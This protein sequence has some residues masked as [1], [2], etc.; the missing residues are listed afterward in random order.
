MPYL[1]DK[2]PLFNFGGGGPVGL[3]ETG[4]HFGGGGAFMSRD[5]FDRVGACMGL[6][7]PGA[8]FVGNAARSMCSPYVGAASSCT[9][10]GPQFGNA[11]T[12][13]PPFSSSTMPP[14]HVQAAWH[15]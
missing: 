15:G 13:G 5:Q 14:R 10:N 4:M 3:R 6:T 2:P 8:A 9:N 11:R 7:G 12:D 1:T